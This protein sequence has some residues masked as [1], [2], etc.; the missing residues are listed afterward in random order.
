MP[1]WAQDY[2]ELY[3]GLEFFFGAFFD[4]TR[5][6]SVGMGPGPIPYLAIH[7]YA[8]I[9]GLGDEDLEEFIYLLCAMDAEYLTYHR[10]ESERK[11]K[12]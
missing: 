2:P 6:R 4:L 11:M 1:A 5:E 10:E 3:M 9:H 12:K 8:Q 7:R